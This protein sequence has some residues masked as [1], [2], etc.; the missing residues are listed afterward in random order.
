MLAVNDVARLAGPSERD[1]LGAPLLGPARIL[2]RVQ[3]TP[4]QALRAEDVCV[5]PELDGW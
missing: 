4:T 2:D 5:T 1:P 3:G